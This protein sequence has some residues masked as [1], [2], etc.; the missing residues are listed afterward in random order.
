MFEF[1]M[2]L[3]RKAGGGFEL[4]FSWLQRGLFLAIFG[5]LVAGMTIGRDL[6]AIGVA[7][8]LVALFGGVFEDAWAWD[9]AARRL[10]HRIGV[11]GL[12][13]KRHWTADSITRLELRRFTRNNL[14]RSSGDRTRPAK[15]PGLFG[16]TQIGLY[17]E[18]RQGQSK[19]IETH[20]LRTN[21]DL[22]EA[23]RLLAEAMA[24]E[25]SES[26]D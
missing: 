16:N 4:R 19:T 9:P 10:T 15:G 6:S 3:Y 5:L 18:D 23:A 7:L 14:A 21:D 11:L 2:N 24:I 26:E 8:T 25:L 13:K 20:R 22:A 1:R 12:S 17:F